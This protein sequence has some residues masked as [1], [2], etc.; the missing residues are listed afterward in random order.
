M[1]AMRTLSHPDHLAEWTRLL[2][3]ERP[4][5][6]KIIAVSSGTCGRARGSQRILETL[7]QEIERQKLG[8]TVAVEATGCHG[9]CEMEPN[10]IIFPEGLFYKNL[11]AKDIPAIVEQTILKNKVIPSLVFQDP[12]TGRKF[13]R[14]E[15]IPFYRNQ[16]RLLTENNCRINPE[17]IED[18]ILLD[19]YQ[20]LAKALFDMTSESVIDEVKASGLRDRGG[21]GL[22]AGKKW[23]VCH[24]VHGHPKYII[25]DA[26]EGDPGMYL[27]RGLLEANPHSLIEG[28]IIGAYSIGA[29]QGFICLP[30]EYPLAV[31]HV[32]LALEQ[33]RNHGLLGTAIFGSEF[34]FD[35][36]VVQVAGAFVSGDETSLIAA[37][38]GK[39]AFPRQQP[40]FPA[41][42]GLWGKP[43]NI[44]NVETWANLPVILN[45]GADWFTKIGTVKNP[46]TKIISLGGK[47]NN[48]GLAEVPFGTRLRKIIFDIGGG[49]KKRRVFKAVQ[50]G[51]PRG[52]FLPKEKM[53]IPLDDDTL[54]QA[55]VILGTGGMIVMDKDTCMVDAARY[56]L[57]SSSEESCGK[58]VPCRVGTKHMLEILNRITRGQGEASDIV[59]L[60]ELAAVMKAASLC[61]LGRTAPNPVLTTLRYF[62]DE[63]DAHIR[64]RRCPALV[65]QGF[66]PEKVKLKNFHR[67][68]TGRKTL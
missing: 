14:R 33:A 41:Q 36:Q 55:G 26:D 51:G 54:S 63:Y 31:K 38:E 68:E 64:E 6:V 43:T 65:C 16:V 39:K 12:V 23:E 10:L 4:S 42:Q 29:S 32:S 2:L 60:E 27:N 24:N 62:R 17:R 53:D 56:D 34:H 21:D 45:K 67:P 59:R 47:I 15:E 46:G 61:G 7:N 19:G 44:H 9:F 8:S 11:E 37:L 22:L 35:I 50:L 13:P 40:P 30:M 52:G 3:E 48:T 20:A 57:M 49:I 1:T 58:C 5:Y 18:Y 28:M 66:I 25:C